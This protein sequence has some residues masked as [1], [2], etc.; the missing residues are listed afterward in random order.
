MLFAKS[1]ELN[2]R[3]CKCTQFRQNI[4]LFHQK[5]IKIQLLAGKWRNSREREE[6][7]TLNLSGFPPFLT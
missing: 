7:E 4:H 3:L 5:N 6:A 1:I 2:S